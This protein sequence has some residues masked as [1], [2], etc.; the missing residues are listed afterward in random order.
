MK[1]DQ[2]NT[3]TSW[4]L[5]PSFVHNYVKTKEWD[6]FNRLQKRLVGD[7]A[8]PIRISLKPPTEEQAISD[9]D[10][11]RIFVH[12]W[13]D[14][15]S[16]SM[17][18]WEEKNY[19]TL[20]N[21]NVPKAL[22]ISNIDEFY[23]YIG[24]EAVNRS[25]MWASNMRPLLEFNNNFYLVL[26]KHLRTIEVLSPNTIG[27]IINTLPQL[28]KN[29]GHGK[30]LREIPLLGVDTK[31]IE[32]HESFIVDLL[33]AIHQN[34]ISSGLLEWLGCNELPS[35]WLTI[36]PLCQHVR[37]RLGGYSLLQL[38]SSELR[39]SEL[40]ADNILV[41]EN[42]QSGLGLTNLPS[43][44]AI[45]GGGKNIS[46]MNAEWLASKNVAYW[47]DIDTWGFAILNDAR[48]VSPNLCSLMMDESTLFK[49]RDRAVNETK[50]YDGV[51]QNLTDLELELFNNLKGL[52][53]HQMR[54]EQERLPFEYIKSNL[55]T[56]ANV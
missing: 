37:E 44:A 13:R 40:P 6:N 23:S 5:L 7:I 1:T 21:Q 32:T 27:M 17:I 53:Y 52:K 47:G 20:K 42:L 18:E 31:F 11:F 55:D 26:I 33:N 28:R 51:L 49:F 39:S 8:F 16:P 15:S 3:E 36:K 9:L 25:R 46:W 19:R 38:T 10:H 48:A 45:I 54:L 12:G 30:Y 24:E 50:Q 35:G 34:Q 22:I 2:H 56:W 14:F 43:T 4:G 29:M 41:V